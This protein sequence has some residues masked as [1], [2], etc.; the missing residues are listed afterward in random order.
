MRRFYESFG[1]LPDGAVRDTTL[2]G[3]APLPEVRYRLL[4]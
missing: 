3:G 1:L 4:H 2:L